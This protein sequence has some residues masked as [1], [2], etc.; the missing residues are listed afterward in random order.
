MTVNLQQ[1]EKGNGT[2]KDNI[3]P[4]LL[5]FFWGRKDSKGTKH[6]LAMGHQKRGLPWWHSGKESTCQ[7]RRPRF[8]SWV[9]KIPWRRKWQPGLI[10][11][12][13]ESHG[14]RSLVGY[15]PWD[16][17]ESDT[18]ERLTLSCTKHSLPFTESFFLPLFTW[19]LRRRFCSCWWSSLS[20]VS[21]TCQWLE[22]R[23]DL[24][25]LLSLHVLGR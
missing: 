21:N 24:T 16:H 4:Q 6:Y 17:Q 7:C 23:L 18:T 22:S 20:H 5:R 2:R 10:F 19:R 9:R 3:I 8:D 13:G 25:R 15:S 12:P 14:E 11:L 1:T